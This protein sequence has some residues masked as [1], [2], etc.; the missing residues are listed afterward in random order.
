MKTAINLK[1]LSIFLIVVA[2]I[3][4]AF[5]AF[6]ISAKV[7]DYFQD[8][9][10]PGTAVSEA[11][12]TVELLDSEGNVVE[13]PS[14]LAIYGASGGE[15]DKI[16]VTI[17]F[18]VEKTIAEYSYTVE[19]YAAADYR[20]VVPMKVIPGPPWEPEPPSYTPPPNLPKPGQ[21]PEKTVCPVHGFIE[22]AKKRCPICGAQ[23]EIY[24]R[25]VGYLRP[26]DR[27]NPGKQEEFRKRR[28]YRV[29]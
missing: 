17:E 23:T 9:F 27:W 25:V 18:T 24:S 12:L 13:K 22:G 4:F 8:L 26:V 20:E 29:K 5:N 1:S 19:V 21:P 14:A 15:V 3:L 7:V 6:G 2:V 11:V 16:R 10:T 28:V